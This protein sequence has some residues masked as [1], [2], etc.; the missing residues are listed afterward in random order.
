AVIHGR[1]ADRLVGKRETTRLCDVYV[2][3]HTGAE[4]KGRAKALRNVRWKK[5]EEPP[6]RSSHGI[7]RGQGRITEGWGARCNP[8]VFRGFA[9]R[10]RSVPVALTRAA[11]RGRRRDHSG[12]IRSDLTGRARAAPNEG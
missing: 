1:T 10:Q 11:G 2:H 5:R 9:R 4:A 12:I 6:K 8:T 3:P 7:S